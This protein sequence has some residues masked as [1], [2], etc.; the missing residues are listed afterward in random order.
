MLTTDQE[1]WGLALWV[2]KHHG[3]GGEAYIQ[4]RISHF[5]E[6]GDQGGAK[7]W[8]RVAERYGQLGGARVPIHGQPG[9]LPN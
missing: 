6:A 2:E 4:Q 3:A 7:L 8:R 1:T 9:T 5:E